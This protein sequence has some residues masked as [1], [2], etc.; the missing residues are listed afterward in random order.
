LAVPLAL[1]P[2]DALAQDLPP[3]PTITRASDFV[4][5]LPDRV[6]AGT[7]VVFR[8]KVAAA[9]ARPPLREVQVRVFSLRAGKS[10]PEP[11]H[12]VDGCDVYLCVVHKLQSINE[13]DLRFVTLDQGWLNM[14][15]SGDTVLDGH[16]FF[17]F[18]QPGATHEQF[19]I[20]SADA[21]SY[22]AAG[23]RISVLNNAS[24]PQEAVREAWKNR[25]ESLAI[26]YPDIEKK[27]VVPCY[28][29]RRLSADASSSDS[30]FALG[31]P[32]AC[33]SS[34]GESPG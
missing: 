23:F 20:R 21:K 2:V 3:R 30:L 32:V 27:G 8:R 29:Y 16:W 34:D 22:F 10:V 18:E 9:T 4:E 6:P 31:Q 14:S 15:N 5:T 1:A 26:L 12:Q 7:Q 24:I 33:Q 25:R 19:R 13:H 11:V 17:V 28:S